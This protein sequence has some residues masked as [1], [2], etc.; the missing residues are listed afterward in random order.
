MDRIQDVIEGQLSLLPN[1]FNNKF[2][3][4]IAGI[5]GGGCLADHPLVPASV[6][7]QKQQN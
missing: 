2:G 5:F 6:S 3:I 4:K 7:N 1:C